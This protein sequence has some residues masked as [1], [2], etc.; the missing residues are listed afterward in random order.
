MKVSSRVTRNWPLGQ[1]LRSDRLSTE[2]TG[3]KIGLLVRHI[4]AFR[5]E[6]VEVSVMGQ[7]LELQLEELLSI[8]NQKKTKV[9]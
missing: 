8:I 4:Q 7:E 9:T 2:Y 1:R 5:E 3:S 6:L